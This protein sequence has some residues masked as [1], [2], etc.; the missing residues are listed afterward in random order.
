MNYDDYFQSAGALSG[1]YRGN[2]ESHFLPVRAF[3]GNINNHTKDDDYDR[4]QE[5]LKQI[6]HGRF[7]LSFFKMRVKV[8]GLLVV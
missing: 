8:R 1:N 3:Q 6:D 7:I 2:L 5:E 4:N